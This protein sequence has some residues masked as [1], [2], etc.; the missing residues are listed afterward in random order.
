MA[1]PGDAWV[2]RAGS[3]RRAVIED[4]RRFEGPRRDGTRPKASDDK[5]PAGPT[6]WPAKLRIGVAK[7]ARNVMRRLPGQ[8]LGPHASTGDQQ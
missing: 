2:H 4:P 7:S 6:R 8:W 5:A 3:K 1:D